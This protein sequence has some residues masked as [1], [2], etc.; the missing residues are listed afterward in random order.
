MQN[1]QNTNLINRSSPPNKLKFKIYFLFYILASQLVLMSCSPEPKNTSE[2][3]TPSDLTDLDS[4]EELI[5]GGRLVTKKNEIAATTISLIDTRQGTLCT[6]TLLSEDIAI[7]AAHCLDGNTE[8]LQISFGTKAMGSETREIINK[9]ISPR[10]ENHQNDP[11]NTGDIAL[12]QFEGGLPK[13]STPATLLKPQHKLSNGEIVTLAGFGL[14]TQD[15]DSAGRLRSVDVKIANTNFSQT[16][17]S[18]DQTN[19]KGACHGD[20]GGPAFIQDNQGGLLLWGVTSRGVNDPTDQCRG[21]SVY[22]RIQA[23]SRWINSTVKKWRASTK[24]KN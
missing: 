12:I 5:I 1:N 22:T 18:L 9:A 8:D 6:A 15:P 21:Q 10:W 4:T 7:T 14:S 3:D 24:N 2:Q 23:Y 11:I 17:V 20:S 16:E 19:K 13:K